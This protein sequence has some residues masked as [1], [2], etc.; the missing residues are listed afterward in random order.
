MFY[1]I[2]AFFHTV[3]F[4]FISPPRYFSYHTCFQRN[5][6]IYARNFPEKGKILNILVQRGEG[7]RQRGGERT[8]P[9]R[10]ES[11]GCG[12]GNTEKKLSKKEISIYEY[13]LYVCLLPHSTLL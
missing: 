12:G 6:Y 9:S 8:G 1:S 13:R 10:N 7:R 3:E 2:G 4:S 5:I 11:F